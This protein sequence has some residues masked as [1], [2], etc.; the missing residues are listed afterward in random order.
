M[1]VAC[2]LA[3]RNTAPERSR[4]SQ[5]ACCKT[6]NSFHASSARTARKTGGSSFA[7]CS[8]ASHS[9]RRSSSATLNR[10]PRISSLRIGN[11]MFN[12][13]LFQNGCRSEPAMHQWMQVRH[14]ELSKWLRFWRLGLP[15]DD[16]FSSSAGTGEVS[17]AYHR[18]LRAVIQ[19]PDA[20]TPSHS[21]PRPIREHG[22]QY[23]C[24]TA[25]HHAQL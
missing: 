3:S 4:P 13:C 8:T 19:I 5:G 2:H 7:S 1:G 21:F 10:N 24:E 16:G 20:T 9:P 11:C 12:R 23:A 18:H 25:I 17:L 14:P 6:C 15:L 22:R